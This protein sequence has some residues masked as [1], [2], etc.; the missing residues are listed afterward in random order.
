M[1][2]TKLIASVG[3][4]MLG[5]SALAATE[6]AIDI[7][8]LSVHSTNAGGASVAFGGLSH[9]GSLVLSQDGNSIL[10]GVARD[11]VSQTITAGLSMIM[12]G[13]IDL[14]AGAVTGGYVDVIMSDG[15]E[16]E[17]QL[18]AGVGVITVQAGQGF[19][20]DGLLFGGLFT[21][22]G[23]PGFVN[24][25][26]GVNITDFTVE[27]PLAGSF[28]NFAYAPDANGLD[29]NADLDITLEI[30][31]VPLPTTAALGFAAL[32]GIASRRRRS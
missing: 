6:L 8:S 5:G 15:S 17:A 30:D 28:L 7:N 27:E 19:K 26:A 18:V 11:G 13:R 2:H 16:F 3:A 12:G 1:L 29:L 9:T 14:V 32:A 21:D 4:L 23:L 25:F 10:A 22:S 31:T 24:E 20:V